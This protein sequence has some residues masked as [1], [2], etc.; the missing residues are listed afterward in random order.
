M[1]AKKPPELKN[2]CRI[3]I[4]AN[5]KGKHETHGWQ[6]KAMRE[7]KQQTKFFA[8]TVMG[9]REAALEAAQT[10][11]DEQLLLI[12]DFTGHFITDTVPR[13]NTSGILGVHR[14]ESIRQDES[15]EEVWQA[16]TP[17]P[18]P[19]LHRYRAF[20]INTHG[21]KGAL[22]KTVE[23]RLEAISDLIG[24]SHFQSSQ[25]AIKRLVDTYLNI[26]IYL[27]SANE[28]DS[29]YLLS[30][31]NSRTI[32]STDKQQIIT[33]RVGQAGYRD[34][35][36]KLWHGRCAVTGARSLLSASHMKPWADSNDQERLDPFNG[37][38]LSPVYDKAF[39]QGLLT[40]TDEGRI[41]VS[42]ALVADVKALGINAAAQIRG[43]NP[44]SAPYLEFHRQHVYRPS[45]DA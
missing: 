11:R 10:Y 9:S 16:S 1:S 18:K 19:G 23:E 39:D 14:S 45:G 3:D 17:L 43:L 7:G 13:S 34:K 5:G 8:D 41:L 32:E 35:L 33:G 40:F 37:L 4:K 44:L 28:T 38:L 20:R 2:I 42:P 31:I 15:I 24:V 26:L 12:G 6:F 36:D 22:Y 27:D 30:V 29:G 21:E 25:P